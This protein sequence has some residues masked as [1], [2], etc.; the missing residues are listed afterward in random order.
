MKRG[1]L[2]CFTT[3]LTATWRRF[4]VLPGRFAHWPQGAGVS[5]TLYTSGNRERGA[6]GHGVVARPTMVSER[7][8]LYLYGSP[9]SST[10]AVRQGS[11]RDAALRH[12]P[13]PAPS[14][15][16]ADPAD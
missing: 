4:G 2:G 3:I 7:Q 16:P 14:P 10:A 12:V 9:R 5:I 8:V 15:A 1:P 13:H 6:C 11:G